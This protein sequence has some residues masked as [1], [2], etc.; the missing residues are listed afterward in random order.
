MRRGVGIVWTWYISFLVF[1]LS[2]PFLSWSCFMDGGINGFLA[3][4]SLLLVWLRRILDYRTGDITWRELPHLSFFAF[5]CSTTPKW[6]S[7]FFLVTSHTAQPSSCWFNCSVRLVS[8]LW[9]TPAYESCWDYV[10]L[11]Y[12]SLFLVI[13]WLTLGCVPT[14]TLWVIGAVHLGCF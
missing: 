5:S 1:L 13:V 9:L 11:G 4:F 2:F 14:P 3:Y 6:V 8:F 10:T 12:D 7:P